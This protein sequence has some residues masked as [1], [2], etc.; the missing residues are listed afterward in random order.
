MVAPSLLPA[1]AAAAAAAAASGGGAE[2]HDLAGGP[3][4]VFARL[5]PVRADDV[6]LDVN[7]LSHGHAVPGLAEHTQQQ[8]LPISVAKITPRG[9]DVM[10]MSPD[11]SS[12]TPW[13]ADTQ[14]SRRSPF[15]MGGVELSFRDNGRDNGSPMALVDTPQQPSLASNVVGSI[16]SNVGTRPCAFGPPRLVLPRPA[17]PPCEAPLLARA[18]ILS[19]CPAVAAWYTCNRRARSPSLSL[20]CLGSHASSATRLEY[21]HHLRQPRQD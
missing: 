8:I 18:W 4:P 20:R 15:S 2:L 1:P 3:S 5:D 14:Y 7:A 10:M 17:S 9:R 6:A 21:V 19:L 16:G 12:G 13:L 11:S